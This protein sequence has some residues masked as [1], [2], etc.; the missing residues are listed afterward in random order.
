MDIRAAATRIPIAGRVVIVVWHLLMASPLAIAQTLR[1]YHIDVEQADA[2]LLVS[3]SGKTLLVD[4]G[5]NGHGSR[6]KTVMDQ[7]SVTD[8][9]FFVNTHYHEDHYGGIDDL[10]D[11]GVTVHKAFDRGDKEEL[12]A[13]DQGEE[14]FKDYQTAIGNLAEQLA[15]GD[16]I[17][18]DSALVIT[19]VASG[20]IVIGEQSPTPGVDENDKSIALVIEFGQFKYFIGGDI[21]LT[22][23]GKLAQRDLVL[24]VDVY[25]ANHHGSQTSSSLPFVADLSPTVVIISNGN[26]GTYKHPRQHTLNTFASLTPR[27]T[28]FQ[29]NKYLKGGAGG[30][31]PDEFIADVESTEK[32]GTILVTVNEAA[33]QYVVS[34][35]EEAHTFLVKITSPSTTGVVIESVLPDPIGND[36]Q[37]E[38]TTLKNKSGNPVS[39]SGWSLRDGD[40]HVVDLSGQGEILPGMS[41]VIVRQGS[42]FSLENNGDSI[43][44]VGANGEVVD[45]Y[46]YSDSSEGQQIHTGH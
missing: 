40:N 4:S 42:S 25:H 36:R 15:K 3:P 9:D 6:I 28:V 2:T 13:A 22:T 17:A 24:D 39:L 44:L 19:C 31:V 11:L 29:T 37:L 1:I 34:Y 35:G 7:A 5:K 23:E 8:I 21:E 33:S 27:P 26:N 12:S 46:I 14:A 16:Q 41:L 38:E 30:N 18:L 20:G 10:V 32:D 45:S 43:R